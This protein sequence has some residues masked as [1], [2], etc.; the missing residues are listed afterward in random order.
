MLGVLGWPLVLVLNPSSLQLTWQRHLH[1][2][3]SIPVQQDSAPVG[4]AADTV[5]IWLPDSL[6]SLLVSQGSL[7]REEAGGFLSPLFLNKTAGTS[8]H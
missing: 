3:F 8:D 2:Q 6:F 5:S 7:C 4:L 1:A